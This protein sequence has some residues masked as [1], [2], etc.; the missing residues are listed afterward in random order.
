MADNEVLIG[1]RTTGAD[2]AA[3]QIK[4]VADAARTVG[5]SAAE[6]AP[7]TQ[8]L[9]ESV[10]S[11]AE[12]SMQAAT[13]SEHLGIVLDTARESVQGL[14]EGVKASGTALQ[15]QREALAG[16]RDS[17]IEAKDQF[18]NSEAA[19]KQ[20]D[21]MI[22]EVNAELEL[23]ADVAKGSTSKL[24]ASVTGVSAPMKTLR[25]QIDAVTEKFRTGGRVTP[26]E[27]QKIRTAQVAVTDAVKATGKSVEE[28]GPTFKKAM[29]TADAE[30]EDLRRRFVQ[31]QEELG[32]FKRSTN[33]AGMQFQSFG[34]TVMQMTGP[35]GAKIGVLAL[36]IK[37]ITSAMTEAIETGHK[38]FGT[39]FTMWDEKAASMGITAADLKSKFR[40]LANNG[41][42]YVG[43]ALQMTM[44]LM[45]LDFPEA[46][47][48]VGDVV[49]L[50]GEHMRDMRMAITSSSEEWEVYTTNAKAAAE[51]TKAAT[52]AT[53][54]AQTAWTE[55]VEGM[56]PY[57]D[58]LTNIARE[59]E[60]TV[61]AEDAARAALNAT[62]QSRDAAFLKMGQYGEVVSGLSNQLGILENAQRKAAEQ[63]A[64]LSKTRQAGDPILDE[65]IRKEK[66]ATTA[67]ENHKKQLSEAQTTLSN[68]EAAYDKANTAIT[69]HEK[70]LGELE[71]KNEDLA[72]AYGAT[73][74]ASDML[75]AALDPLN[76]RIGEVKDSLGLT[77][78]HAFQLGEAFTKMDFGNV[79]Q[80]FAGLDSVLGSV[81]QKL[82]GIL[83]KLPAATEGIA[84]FGRSAEE[85]AGL[86]SGFGAGSPT[87]APPLPK[88]AFQ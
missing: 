39:D 37:G 64:E 79:N 54:A 11:V 25:D 36:A 52:E 61:R 15:D 60:A 65:A 8:K 80:Q 73:K 74:A 82:A 29:D 70:K 43:S 85:A 62:T 31:M 10:V 48:I 28:M 47:R 75:F 16:L 50:V 32:R 49:R 51:A 45:T 87:S 76:T 19:A 1:V 81:E 66:S 72:Q 44:A 26:A 23:M 53:Q 41:F 18:G 35:M 55:A 71:T 9:V 34:T 7:D 38:L 69:G 22:A 46:G 59:I 88:G 63:V 83:G 30:V 57:T 5:E 86:K 42:E 58:A 84:H 3:D 67:V 20:F 68:S 17:L 21:V 78:D 13:E 4:S 27:I 12:K 33:E 40:E 14:T 2:D 24:A 6:A 56:K 77:K